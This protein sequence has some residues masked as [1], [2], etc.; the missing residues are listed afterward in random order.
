[1]TRVSNL[2]KLLSLPISFLRLKNRLS[3]RGV[4]IGWGVK[5][6]CS[7]DCI[8]R[9]TFIGHHAT[10]GP[11]TKAIGSFCSIAAYSIIGPN[12]HH[13][14]GISTSATA[15]KACN[16]EKWSMV[17]RSV[18]DK[19]RDAQI[20]ARLNRKKTVLSHD[21][22]VGVHAI[23]LPGVYVAQGA[24]VGAGSVVT[25]D[26]EPYSIVAGNP[27]VTVRL[28]FSQATVRKLLELKLFDLR[29]D[30]LRQLL[31]RYALADM[32][33]VILRFEEEFLFLSE[34]QGQYKHA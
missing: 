28:R 14:Q 31:S 10:V 30:L 11:A 17:N 4:N 34:S 16:N 27:A 24:V 13:L 26:V 25:K 21:V 8:G 29:E 23:I 1:M 7:S 19:K 32:D 15:Y 12:Q 20:K 22:W 18:E 2:L 6:E 3:V 9:S 33:S 5:V